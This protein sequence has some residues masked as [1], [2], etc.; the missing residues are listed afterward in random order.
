MSRENVEIV[1]RL[2]E[3]LA[4]DGL[5]ATL[6]LFHPDVVW[7]DLDLLPGAGTYRGHAGLRE[8]FARFYDAW[9]DLAFDAEQLI[10]AGDAVVVVGHRWHGTGKASGTPIDTLVWNVLWL[11]EGKLVRRQAFQTRDAALEAA[12]LSK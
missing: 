5:E 7:E 8:A 4:E 2:Y 1:R 9:G 11:R 3:R 10:D 6:D 12:G